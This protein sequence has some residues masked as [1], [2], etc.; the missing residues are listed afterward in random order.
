MRVSSI[1]FGAMLWKLV[2][3]LC[4]VHC[5]GFENFA[6][7]ALA[8]QYGP[9]EHDRGRDVDRGICADKY[10]NENGERKIAQHGATKEIKGSD[11]KQRCAAGENRAAQRLVD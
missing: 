2:F 3:A 7:D 5:F 8:A 4:P 11:R 6:P 9:P 1:S 10:A